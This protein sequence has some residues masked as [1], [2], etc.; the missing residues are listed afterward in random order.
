MADLMPELNGRGSI[1]NS[2]LISCVEKSALSPNRRSISGLGALTPKYLRSSSSL[3]A[4]EIGIVTNDR[5]KPLASAQDIA[6]SR[7]VIAG[8]AT[9]KATGFSQDFRT[10]VKRHSTRSSM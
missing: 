8:P 10:G 7:Q 6:I 1:P 9:A 4:G 2:E 5:F 3:I